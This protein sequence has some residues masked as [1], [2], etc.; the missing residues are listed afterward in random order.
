MLTRSKSLSSA[1]G[2]RE[3]REELFLNLNPFPGPDR[4]PNLIAVPTASN[5][6]VKI[7]PRFFINPE[8]ILLIG[9]D[10]RKSSATAE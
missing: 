8:V 5:Y 10:R 3:R 9:I 7:C 4:S 6:F 2:V 1:V